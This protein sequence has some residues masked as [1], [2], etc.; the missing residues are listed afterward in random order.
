[1]GIREDLVMSVVR[2][3]R[4]LL[5]VIGIAIG[6]LEIQTRFIGRALDTWAQ[7]RTL[8]VAH[9]RTSEF[10]NQW[11]GVPAAQFPADFMTY[12]DLIWEVKPDYIIE[13]G[14]S[15]GGLTLFLASVLQ[16][17]NPEGKVISLDITAELW[18]DTLARGLVPNELAERII[19]IEGDDLSDTVVGQVRELVAG[20]KALVILDTLHTKEH[21]FKELQVYREFVSPKSYLVVNDTHHDEMYTNPGPRAAVHEFLKQGGHSFVLRTDLPRFSV[22][23]IKEGVLQRVE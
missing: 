19:F 4:I 20:K 23:G 5:L 10:V 11:F 12:Q 1:M 7:Q 15:Y 18:G 22:S 6:L 17:I 2:V 21:V 13:A 16:H 9:Y 14:T 3:A 8:F